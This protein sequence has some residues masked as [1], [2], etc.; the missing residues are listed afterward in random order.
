M[1]LIILALLLVVIATARGFVGAGSYDST[2]ITIAKLGVLIW[3]LG[4]LYV[5]YVTHTR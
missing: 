2:V 3:A 5:L 4:T 1:T